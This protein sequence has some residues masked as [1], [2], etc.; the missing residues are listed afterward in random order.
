MDPSSQKIKWITNI[1]TLFSQFDNIPYYDESVK[2]V[3]GNVF[4]LM[5]A[6]S[7]IYKFDDF[8][9]VFKD[10]PSNNIVTLDAGHWVHFEKPTETLS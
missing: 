4:F 9:N 1:E 5:G 10:L 6:R 3:G 2:G 7:R 8:T